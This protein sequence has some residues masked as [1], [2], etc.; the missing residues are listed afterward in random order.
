MTIPPSL[1]A[2]SM[3]SLARAVADHE[4]GKHPRHLPATEEIVGTRQNR[5]HVVVA[6][7]QQ[8][9]R[10]ELLQEHVVHP[11]AGRGQVDDP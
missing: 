6:P 4:L 7:P 2:R 1:A 11:G 3:C 8:V 10:R 5:H 9:E